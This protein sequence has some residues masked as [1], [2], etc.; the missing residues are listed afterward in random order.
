MLLVITEFKID[1]GN[2]DEYNYFIIINQNEKKNIL[3]LS[4]SEMYPKKIVDKLAHT[5]IR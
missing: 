5:K 1:I 3:K 2:E 4:L